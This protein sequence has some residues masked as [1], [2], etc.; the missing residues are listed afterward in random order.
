ML[1]KYGHNGRINASEAPGTP[2][3][4]F[5]NISANNLP[6]SLEIIQQGE[7]IFAAQCAECHTLG[8][9]TIGPAIAAVTERMPTDWL[10]DFIKNPEKMIKSG[11]EYSIFLAQNYN[12]VMPSFDALLSENEIISV[13]S[14]IKYASGAQTHTAGSN[15]NEH[16]AD[17]DPALQALPQP[18]PPTEEPNATQSTMVK[19]AIGVF[20]VLLVAGIIYF[21]IR[22]FRA[23]DKKE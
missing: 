7:S 12:I 4:Y 8:K 22:F 11:N 13:L 5:A 10:T 9:R 6:R 21:L 15:A 17:A 20:G 1:D 3:D 23:L 19:I 18:A 16:M 2:K 14:Y